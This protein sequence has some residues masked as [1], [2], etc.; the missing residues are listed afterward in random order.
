M[1]GMPVESKVGQLLMIG[2]HGREPLP[3]TLALIGRCRPGGLIFFGSNLDRADRLRALASDLAQAVGEG[4]ERHIAPFLSIDQEGG[5]VARLTEDQ[6]WVVFPGN[7]AIGATGPAADSFAFATAQAIGRQLRSVGLNMNLAPVLDVNNN[8]ANPIIGV[9]AF[10]DDP[11][12]VARLGAA[13]VRGFAAAGVA[14]V[15]KHFP[16]HG[17]T[18]TD[19]HVE[20]PA[21]AHDRP[22]LDRVEL[23]PFRS[24]IAAGVDAIMTAHVTFPALDPRPGVPATLS[25]AALTGLL[26]EE[27]GFSGLIMTDALEMKAVSDHFAVGEAAV[28][29]VL[30]GADIILVGQAPDAALE[31]QAALLAAVRSGRVRAEVLD[32]AVGRVLHL[33]RRLGLLPGTGRPRVDAAAASPAADADLA[34][35]VAR[36]SVTLVRDAAGLLPLDPGS[37]GREL[38]LVGPATDP[39]IGSSGHPGSGVGLG[40]HLRRRGAQVAEWLYPERPDFDAIAAAREAVRRALAAGASVILVTAAPRITPERAEL[41]RVVVAE[42][43]SRLVWASLY[44]PYDLVSA[45]EAPAYVVTYSF[46]PASRQALAEALF[47]EI[48]FRGKAPVSIR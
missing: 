23:A 24:A 39:G 5:V 29:A 33:K 3:E 38:L 4:T 2:F 47:G 28:L 44:S 8:P 16:G 27:M 30:A 21:V 13:A 9:R 43:G 32:A 34:L 17:D 11:A 46:R 31:A 25:P 26:R 1:R 12:E 45:P 41:A 35:A 20:L 22:R 7:M 19:S 6:G 36:A 10:S 15:G 40:E 37:T 42:G 48:P 14:S 18:S